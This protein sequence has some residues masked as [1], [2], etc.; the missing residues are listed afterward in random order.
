MS[1][2]EQQDSNLRP[3]GPKPDALPGCAMLRYGAG[4]RVRTADLMIT[5][6]LLYQL[7][8]TGIVVIIL[9]RTPEFKTIWQICSN[10]ST[11]SKA[12]QGLGPTAQTP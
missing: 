11:C 6:Q 5:N 9:G 7:S 4:T 2:S 12:A 1:W 8:Y 3:S 10:L